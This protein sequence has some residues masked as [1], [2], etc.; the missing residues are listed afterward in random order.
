V[1]FQ[2]LISTI[3]SPEVGSVQAVRK[4]RL[5]TFLISAFEVFPQVIQITR[6]GTP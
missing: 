5:S 1:E 2:P 3:A 4:V 6:G